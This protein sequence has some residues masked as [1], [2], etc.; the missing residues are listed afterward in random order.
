MTFNILVI[1]M[2][3]L[4]T[5]NKGYLLLRF[6]GIKIILLIEYDSL[7]VFISRDVITVLYFCVILSYC[8]LALKNLSN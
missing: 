8:F 4:L 5:H 1:V 3:D 2:C 7:Y 6:T